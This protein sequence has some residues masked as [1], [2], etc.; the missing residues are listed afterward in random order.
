V[1]FAVALL[2]GLVQMLTQLREPAL[3]GI[4]RLLS[5]GLV[6]ALSFGALSG[7]LVSFTTRLYR[8]LPALLATL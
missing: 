8:D 7:E 2:V 3:N 6:L 5:V 1:A 4:A